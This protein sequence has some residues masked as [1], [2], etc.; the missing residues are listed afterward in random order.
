MGSNISYEINYVVTWDM[1]L[2]LVEYETSAT[3][4]YGYAECEY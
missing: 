2:A 1:T 3:K 4:D